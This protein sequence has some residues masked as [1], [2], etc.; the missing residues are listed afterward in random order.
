MN[1]KCIICN[2]CPDPSQ[3]ILRRKTNDPMLFLCSLRVELSKVPSN[4]TGLLWHKRNS[5]PN[6][7]YIQ[8]PEFP[9]TRDEKGDLL[10]IMLSFMFFWE[11]SRNQ[12]PVA[13]CSMQCCT[14]EL[15]FVRE[16]F[17][18]VL[19]VGIQ[20]LLLSVLT[21]HCTNYHLTTFCFNYVCYLTLHMRVCMGKF[22]GACLWWPKP[23]DMERWP[24]SCRPLW[25]L[26]T[27][28]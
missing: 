20:Q 22:C 27:W 12:P 6:Y 28:L 26:V 25:D 23:T 24:A 7:K 18:L 8:Y 3:F 15:M 16:G 21:S 10:G 19:C 9:C 2:Y 13:A 17:F 14:G 4:V 5:E 11:Y 1:S